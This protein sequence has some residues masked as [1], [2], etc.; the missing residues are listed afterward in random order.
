MKEIVF[1]LEELSAK[2]MIEKILPKLVPS[3]WTWRFIV[4]QGKQDLEKRLELKL[5]AYNNPDAKFIIL[6]DQDSGDCLKI[7]NLLLEKCKKAK[8][9]GIVRI[10]CRELE[11]WYLADLEAVSKVYSQP[12]LISLQEKEKFRNP[13]LLGSPSEELKKILPEYQKIDGSR[14]IGEALN[15]SN[16]RSKSFYHFIES[17]RRAYL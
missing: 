10:A 14:R 11:S 13:D 4:F 17:I 5:R 8:K 12:S 3:D 16:K 2:A 15:L 9:N 1:L 6:R 7:K